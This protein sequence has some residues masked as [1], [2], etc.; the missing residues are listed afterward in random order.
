MTGWSEQHV[1]TLK[2]LY[3]ENDVPS[4]SLIGDGTALSRFT[5]ELNR[6]LGDAAFSDEEV[7]D[8]LFRLRKDGKLPRLRR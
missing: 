8:E 3:E 7:A 5:Q 4:D 6:R 1:E 2:T